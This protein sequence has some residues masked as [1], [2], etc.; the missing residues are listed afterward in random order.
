MQTAPP[1]YEQIVELDGEPSNSAAPL[2]RETTVEPTEQSDK[3][4]YSD[5]RPPSTAPTRKIK[6]IPKSISIYYTTDKQLTDLSVFW[7]FIFGQ[8]DAGLSG[9][10]III[11]TR[12]EVQVVATSH[13]SDDHYY[14]GT[15]EITVYN[16][17]FRI[18][19]DLTPYLKWTYLE[20]QDTRK[21]NI[22]AL[23]AKY[24]KKK[25]EIEI[26]QLIT[27]D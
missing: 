13:G 15:R 22:H 18:E 21:R 6:P 8:L 2:D 16:E 10:V 11:G 26:E 9:S 20:D 5:S 24:F 27:M 12:S 25:S 23:V 17:D 7:G 3:K 1:A 4:I 19:L 14:S